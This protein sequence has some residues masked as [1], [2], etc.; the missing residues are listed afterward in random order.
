MVYLL[1]PKQN[2][3][4]LHR[5]AHNVVDQD[6]TVCKERITDLHIMMLEII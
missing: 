1:V 2:Q 5:N 4:V 6:P 3:Y